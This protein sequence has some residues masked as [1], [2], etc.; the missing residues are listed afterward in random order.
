MVVVP[1]ESVFNGNGDDDNGDSIGMT[2]RGIWASRVTTSV[3]ITRTAQ[4]LLANGITSTTAIS[5]VL[6]SARVTSRYW[7]PII[8]LVQRSR[9]PPTPT[10]TTVMKVYTEFGDDDIVD[11]LSRRVTTGMW[12]GDT[13]SLLTFFTSSTQS[14]STGDWYYDVYNADPAVDTTAEIQFA[15]AYGDRTGLNYPLIAD[16][17]T[18]KEPTKAIYSQYR[19]T[20]LDPEDD[21]FTFANSWN[22][23]QIF[24]LNMQRARLK[25]KFDAGNWELTLTTGSAEIHLIDDS[26]DKFD[27]NVSQ[28]GR[29]YNVVSGSLNVGSAATV[30]RTAANE[31]SGGLGLFYP[32]RGLILLNPYAIQE[33][34]K[35]AN[36]GNETFATHSSSGVAT[37][38]DSKK[39]LYNMIKTGANFQARNEEVVTSTHY[40]VRVKNRDYNLSNNPSYY[41]SSDGTLKVPTFI[42]DPTTYLTTVGLYDDTNQLLAVA[43]VSTPLLKSFDREALIKVKLDY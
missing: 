26:G 21:K 5:S 43:K 11:N 13:G 18:S 14:G 8:G 37:I 1:R 7:G 25:Q 36:G 29:L 20:L 35:D 31:P 24:V 22:S 40:F 19:N 16:L 39:D 15:I 33:V 17:N 32:D 28:G 38:Y 4:A 2:I 23:D 3:K 34:L 42:G 41:T 30:F 6:A 12:T 10:A 27:Q 9:R